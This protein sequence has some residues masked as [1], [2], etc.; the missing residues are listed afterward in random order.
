MTKI[1]SLQGRTVYWIDYS[2][3]DFSNL[4]KENWLCMARC[5][6]KPDLKKFESFVS[7]SIDH[8]ILEFKGFGAFGEYLH[9]YFDDAIIETHTNSD[10]YLDIATTCHTDETYADTFWQCFF[11][12]TLTGCTDFDNITIV[13]TDLDGNNRSEELKEYLNKFR[14][15]WI[16]EE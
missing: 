15:G 9:H 14:E 1:G 13:C 6:K 11:A 3:F 5:D 2:K 10:K 4:P 8:Q 7:K 12:T 16:P